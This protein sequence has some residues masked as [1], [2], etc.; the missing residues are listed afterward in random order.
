MGLVVETLDNSS[1]SFSNREVT[2]RLYAELSDGIITQ[3]N[4]DEN[5]PVL[6][7]TTTT[8]FNQDLFGSESNLQSDIN[9]GA[10][11]FIPALQYDTWISLGDSYDSAPSTI[12]D[13]GFKFLSSFF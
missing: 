12:G 11:G 2:Y 8:F 9:S 1:A 10:F 7:S 5:N 6:I 3:L 13:L 4:G